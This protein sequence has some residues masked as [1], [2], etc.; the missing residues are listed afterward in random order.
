VRWQLRS[1]CRIS[2]GNARAGTK[3]TSW[4][5]IPTLLSVLMLARSS[6][7]LQTEGGH[8]HAV[9]GFEIGKVLHD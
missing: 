5:E 6:H 2:G 8:R 7:P 3:L 9:A 4:N 1:I